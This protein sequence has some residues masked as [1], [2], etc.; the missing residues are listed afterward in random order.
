MNFMVADKY[1]FIP[2]RKFTFVCASFDLK[3]K[4]RQEYLKRYLSMLEPGGRLILTRYDDQKDEFILLDEYLKQMES[5]LDFL[6][7]GSAEV[8]EITKV[9]W[10]ETGEN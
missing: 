8:H 4:R 2:E 10:L 5:K 9:F 1:K 3:D 7:V 6:F